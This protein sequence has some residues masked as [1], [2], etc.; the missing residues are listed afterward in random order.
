MGGDETRTNDF[1]ALRLLAVALWPASKPKHIFC[2]CACAACKRFRRSGSY[3]NDDSHERGG[4]HVNDTEAAST[5]LG[6]LQPLDVAS[7]LRTHGWRLEMAI[8]EKGSLWLNTLDGSGDEA[9]VTLPLRRDL[10]DYTLRM[11]DLVQVLVRVEARP[12]SEVVA[13]LLTTGSDLIRVRAPA[14]SAAGGS[15]G[16][17]TAVAFAENARD[18]ILAAACAAVVK[19]SYYATKKATKATEYLSRV[20]MGQTE[21]GSYVLTIL[22]PVAPALL[23]VNELPFGPD[24]P[25]PFERLVTRTLSSG[26]IALQFAA[27][28]A[29]SSGGM[30]AFESVVT[31]G[32]SANLCDAVAGLE[33]ASP[34]E[35]V[36]IS[37]TWSRSR[38]L[39]VP[40]PSRIFF[41]SDSIQFIKEAAQ[42]F[43]ETVLAENTELEGFVTKLVRGPREQSGAITL[44][45]LVDGELRRVNMELREDTYTEAVKAHEGRFRVLCEGDLKKERGTFR[46]QD[47][48]HFRILSPDEVS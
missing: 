16:L 48:R 42:R 7:Y 27:R 14:R 40:L 36:E 37:I 38:P 29:A 26:L 22:S 6:A 1:K 9:D 13:D 32:V 8:G 35:G 47:P 10:A 30:D 44:E 4:K 2:N 21:L 3:K 19:R 23:P 31:Q 39:S 5:L 33:T 45:G 46:L 11:A 25:E 12:R 34:G 17:T 15:L 43:K 41:G 24:G 20:R 18:L 28:Q